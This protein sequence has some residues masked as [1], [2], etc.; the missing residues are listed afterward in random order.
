MLVGIANKGINSLYFKD[1]WTFIFEFVPQFLF[2]TCT[3]GYMCVLVILKWLT[4]YHGWENQ[5]PSI[6]GIFINFTGKIEHPII[7][8]GDQQ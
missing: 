7:G 4:N 6:V 3:F 2:M 8:T 1:Y 5:A